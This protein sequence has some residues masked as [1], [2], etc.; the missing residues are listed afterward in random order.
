MAS[1]QRENG[2]TGVANEIL[3]A[4]A[5]VQMSGHEWRIVMALFRETY[6]HQTRRI[7]LALHNGRD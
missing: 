7:I 2:Y 3:E 6:G 4:L 1:P 5:R